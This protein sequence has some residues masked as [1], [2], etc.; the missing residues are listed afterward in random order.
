LALVE[1]LHPENFHVSGA[2]AFLVSVNGTLYVATLGW[3]IEQ[4]RINR[5]R[6]C[7]FV[8]SVV[9]AMLAATAAASLWA[10]AGPLIGAVDTRFSP[11]LDAMLSLIPAAVV[12]GVLAGAVTGALL[13]AFGFRWAHED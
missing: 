13:Q 1:P 2:V 9:I 7:N 10:V 8:E 11:L 6:A 12:G 3:W 5:G 4:A